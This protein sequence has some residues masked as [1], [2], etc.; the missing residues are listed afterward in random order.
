MRRLPCSKLNS[1]WSDFLR[2]LFRD[3]APLGHSVERLGRGRFSLV[4][5]EPADHPSDDNFWD[6]AHSTRHLRSVREHA[7]RILA[8]EAHHSD[9]FA[10]ME[11][12]QPSAIQPTLEIVNFADE[13]HRDIVNYLSLYQSVISRKRVGRQ[14]GLLLWD[15]G[16]TGHRPLIGA[17]VLA[18]P[19]YSQRL[20]DGH[21]GWKPDFPRTSVHF[22]EQTR[23]VR[24]SGLGRMMQLS[25]ACA[26]PPYNVL[27]GAWLVALAPFTALGQQAFAAAAHKEADPDLAAVVTTTGKGISGTPFRGH[28]VGQLSDRRIEAAPGASGDV[29]TRALPMPGCPPL[30]ASFEDLVAKDTLRRAIKLF[31]AENKRSARA[32]SDIEHTAMSYALDRLGLDR[33]IFAGNEMGV[34]IGMLGRDTLGYLGSGTPRPPRK[35]PRLEWNTVVTVWARRFLPQSD[36]AHDTATPETSASHKIGRRRRI[37]AARAYPADRIR[38]SDL[39]K[40]PDKAA[41]SVSDLTESM[42]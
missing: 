28:R 38:L 7:G 20:R 13:R 5:S 41:L 4:I 14:M 9:I 31:S 32:T 26:V 36:S 42:D 30:R 22:D 15:D 33:R 12:F 3:L 11:L 2:L 10:R 40:R 18:S 34:H 35:R 16:Q 25:I 29:F 17:A 23:A 39:L 21:L 24:L 19:R 37:E 8:F 27:S 6:R 1:N